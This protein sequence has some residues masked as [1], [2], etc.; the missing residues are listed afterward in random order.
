MEQILANMIQSHEAIISIARGGYSDKA[1]NNWLT[2]QSIA[3]KKQIEEIKRKLRDDFY[4]DYDSES[5]K[6]SVIKPGSKVVVMVDHMDG[7]KGSPAI[8]RGYSAP[9][10]L[11]DIE[12]DGM[13]MKGHKW[14]TNDEVKLK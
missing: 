3:C 1:M 11:S 8:V 4:I 6:T 9:A 14:L 7:M 2:A 12:M 13:P 5:A 10:M